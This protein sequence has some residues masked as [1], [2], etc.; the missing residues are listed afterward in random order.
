MVEVVLEGP[1]TQL[2]A[3]TAQDLRIYVNLSGLGPGMY[4]IDPVVLAP[5]NV[6]VVNVIPE[7]VEVRIELIPPPT[8]VPIPVVT[9]GS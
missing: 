4:R 5:P 2:N 3:L 8:P 6:R 1:E 7:T 9:P